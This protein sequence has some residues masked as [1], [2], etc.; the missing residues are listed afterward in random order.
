[1]MLGFVV[2][3]CATELGRPPSPAELAEWANN[4]RD[5]R[6]EYRVF[7]RPISEQEAAVI[8]RHPDR[9]VAV[10]STRVSATR[11]RPDV[12]PGESSRVI[13]NDN[14]VPLRLARRNG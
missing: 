2:R 6:G 3:R 14:V 4:Q 13:P 8:L 7:G 12:L 1:M 9:L 11:L 10:K 5:H